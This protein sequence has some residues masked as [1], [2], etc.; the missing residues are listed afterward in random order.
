MEHISRWDIFLVII[1]A[2]SLIKA[3]IVC[4]MFKGDIYN[5]FLNVRRG[6]IIYV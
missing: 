4:I 1:F 5:V 3:Q 6:N 2:H